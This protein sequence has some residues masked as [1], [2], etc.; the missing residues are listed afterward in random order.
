MRDDVLAIDERRM[1]A[2]QQAAK[3]LRSQAVTAPDKVQWLTHL[4]ETYEHLA[5]MINAP[6]RQ[7]V[8]EQK[9]PM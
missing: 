8:K 9:F 7:T 6:G 3:E 2:W 4:A 1:R 5:E